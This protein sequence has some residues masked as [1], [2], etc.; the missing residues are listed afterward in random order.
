MWVLDHKEGWLLKNWYSWTVVLEKTLESPL[1]CKEIKQI[2]P[3]GNE[4][5]MFIGKTCW[6]WSS[7]PLATLCEELTHLEK[8]LMLGKIEGRRRGW[9][10][11][12]VGWPH[13]LN[14]H[15]F[16]QTLGDGEGQGRLVCCSP[17]GHKESDMTEWLNNSSNDN[18]NNKIGRMM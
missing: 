8:V 14:G 9:Q 4:L 11:E 18:N 7:N 17:W 15:E 5:W 1:D 16:E 6:R 10:N 3:E 12:M 2:R 13:Q